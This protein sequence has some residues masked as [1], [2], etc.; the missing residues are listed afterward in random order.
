MTLFELVEGLS[1]LSSTPADLANPQEVRDRVRFLVRR[2]AYGNYEPTLHDFDSFDGRLVAWLG[3][4]NSNK[5]KILMLR[6]LFEIMYLGGSEY[7]ALYKAAFREHV[8]QWL[9]DQEE[10]DIVSPDVDLLVRDAAVRT[11]FSAA[12]DSMRINSFHT[13]NNIGNGFRP[14]WRSLMRATGGCGV[15][16]SL[17]SGLLEYMKTKGMGRVVMLE[18]FVGSL[19]QGREIVEFV[20]QLGLPILFVPL[21]ICPKGD[22]VALQL[23]RDFPLLTYRPVYR[24][25]DSLF[26]KSDG[27]SSTA[28]LKDVAKFAVREYG[29]VT[30]GIPPTDTDE[31]YGPFGKYET[32]ALFVKYTNCP[33]NTLPLVHYQ[34]DTWSA[35]FPRSARG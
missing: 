28:L 10:I 8:V 14:E 2:L 20:A 15:C 23:E 32:G 9:V 4:A 24:L 26:V 21:V 16:E 29:R 25:S 19:T 5:D 35:L 18:D 34:S 3:C 27:T 17:K 22:E 7:T 13:V 30:D 31:P 1:T 11:C 6:L 12:T 33:D